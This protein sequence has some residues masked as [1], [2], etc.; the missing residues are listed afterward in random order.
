MEAIQRT[1]KKDA[2]DHIYDE[3]LHGDTVVCTKIGNFSIKD[4]VGTEGYVL[5]IDG[6]WTKYKHCRL[7]AKNRET[8]KVIFEDGRSIQCTPDHKFLTIKGEWVEAKDLFNEI[9]YNSISKLN[10][11]ETICKSRLLVKQNRNLMVNYIGYAA[12]I[13]KEKVNDFIGLFGNTIKV[14]YQKIIMFIIKMAIDI[15]IK[16]KILNVFLKN[17]MP[18]TMQICEIL[19]NGNEH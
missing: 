16:L 8:I 17:L 19:Q 10:K 3:C 7:I 2:E 6:K 18:Q 1:L 12:N 13:F 4:L 5:T 11:E 14:L 9:C 15:T